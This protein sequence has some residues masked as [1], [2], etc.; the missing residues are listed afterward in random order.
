[1]GDRLIALAAFMWTWWYCYDDYLSRLVD[2]PE[3]G[4]VPFFI[5]ILAWFG[6]AV[7]VSKD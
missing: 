2:N 4:A 3:V 5:W 7:I 6:L 1:M